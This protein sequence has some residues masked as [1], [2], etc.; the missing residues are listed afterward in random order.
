MKQNHIPLKVAFDITSVQ[1]GWSI[2]FFLILIF[3]NI[4]KYMFHEGGEIGN[5]FNIT[6]SGSTVFMLIIG[7]IAAYTFL[8]LYVNHGIT[9]KDYFVGNTLAIFF[10]SLVLLAVSLIITG[11]EY[12]IVNLTNMDITFINEGAIENEE[13]IIANFVLSIVLSSF[14]DMNNV[15]WLL[16]IGVFLIRA[17]FFYAIGWFI[18]ASFYRA[19]VI[20]GFGSIAFS[21]I[22]VS[23][24]DLFWEATEG[25]ILA[26][27]LSL[28]FGTPSLFISF[29]GSCFLIAFLF[30]IIRT[31]TKR[32][33]VLL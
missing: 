33:S 22:L 16:S 18:G 17:M 11:V 5:F 23:L 21:I 26:Q 14:G 2:I 32:V 27:Y 19:G 10:I 7:I 24:F 9:R 30:V 25:N 13:N 6:F 8:P 15:P 3:N 4:I 29:I 31:I 28:D 20:A 1:S 12:T